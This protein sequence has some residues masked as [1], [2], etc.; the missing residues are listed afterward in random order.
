MIF[1]VTY[2]FNTPADSERFVREKTTGSADVGKI[3]FIMSKNYLLIIVVL[4]LMH[5]YVNG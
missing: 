2:C 5:L 3:S 1:R 4:A